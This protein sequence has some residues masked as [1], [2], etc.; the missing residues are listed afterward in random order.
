MAAT[1]VPQ[2][3]HVGPVARK[4]RWQ[5]RANGQLRKKGLLAL[6]FLKSSGST[7]ASLGAPLRAPWREHSSIKVPSSAG[8]RPLA[9]ACVS[10]VTDQYH[11]RAF[12][13]RT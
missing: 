11:S 5:Q 13:G 12:A 7:F 8:S 6:S 1:I 4:P 9:C 2:R 10:I 3:K